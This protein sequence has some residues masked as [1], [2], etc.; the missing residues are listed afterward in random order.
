MKNKGFTLIEFV[1]ALGI[2][3]LIIGLGSTFNLSFLKSD[4]LKSEQSKVVSLLSRARSL[5]MN[6]IHQSPHGFC[7][8]SPNYII[9]RDNP[10]TKCVLG[11]I[12]NQVFPAET[13]TADNGG[14]I[15]P[16]VIIFSQLAGTTTVA[17]IHLTDGVKSLDVNINSEGTIEW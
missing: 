12:T 14:T 5:S 10:G 17:N 2:F 3:V 11:A 15:F 7:Y 6:N 4:I 13:S 1:V 8:I 9:F 16:N